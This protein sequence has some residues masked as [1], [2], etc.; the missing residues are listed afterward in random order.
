M[1][2]L[3]DMV[4]DCTC[5]LFVGRANLPFNQC[6]HLLNAWN[7]NKRVQISR[8]GQEIEPGV[9][10]LLVSLWDKLPHH[11]PRSKAATG[12]AD[13]MSRSPTSSSASS[14]SYRSG[15]AGGV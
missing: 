3:G 2:V 4:N 12:A 10:E 8:D 6:H 15:A 7:E 9:G 13:D 11:T 14:S 1:Y 5:M